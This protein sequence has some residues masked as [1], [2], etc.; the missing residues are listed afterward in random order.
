ML[1]LGLSIMIKYIKES[2]GEL[3]TNV[4]WPTW[5]NAQRM[6]VT[7]A[8]FSVLFSVN[9]GLNIRSNFKISIQY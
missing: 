6:T 8:V 1:E 9:Y 2:F 4:A 5:A 3:K 7:V